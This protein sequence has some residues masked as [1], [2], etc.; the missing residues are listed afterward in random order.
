LIRLVDGLGWFQP[1]QPQ[2]TRTNLTNLTNLTKP[3]Q[4]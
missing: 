1:G 2:P 4:T 3:D